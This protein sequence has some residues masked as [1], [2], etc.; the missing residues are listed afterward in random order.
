MAPE[1]YRATQKPKSSTK[2]PSQKT[3]SPEEKRRRARLKRE[4]II[5]R[6]KEILQ[7][8]RLRRERRKRLFILSFWVAVIL[9]ALYWTVVAISITNR[10]DG[11]KN[12]LPLLLFEQGKRE[13]KEE[14]LPEEICIGSTKYLPVTFLNDFFAIS[15]FGDQKTRS[16]LI[17][18]NGEFATFYLNNEEIVING[19]RVSMQAPA[20]MKD[21]KLFLP[22]DFYAEKMSCFELGKNNT[23]YGADV[24][25]FLN[26]RE[27]TFTFHSCPL[28]TPVDYATVPIAPTVPAEPT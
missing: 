5:R 13:E 11:S 24:L 4:E 6:K 2:K 9:V 3:L 18:S 22:I 17:C 19:E 14:Y 10:P 27:P 28:E 21:G 15:E 8:K 25:T 1:R 26:D 7:Q 20:L 12:A 23:T 16:F